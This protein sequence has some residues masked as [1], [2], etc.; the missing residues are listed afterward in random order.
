MLLLR[1]TSKGIGNPFAADWQVIAAVREY[2]AVAGIVVSQQR[3]RTKS[4]NVLR[5]KLTARKGG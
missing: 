1:Q 4:M 5:T 2:I 3:R